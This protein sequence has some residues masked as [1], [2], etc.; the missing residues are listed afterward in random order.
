MFNVVLKLCCALYNLELKG[1][2]HPQMKTCSKTTFFFVV[3]KNFRNQT[4]VESIDFHCMETKYLS[5]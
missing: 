5:K 1:I 4:T 3:P 2:A